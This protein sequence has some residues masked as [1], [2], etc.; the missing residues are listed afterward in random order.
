V[1]LEEEGIEGGDVFDECGPAAGESGGFDEVNNDVGGEEDGVVE[2][3][4]Y[5]D[6]DVAHLAVAVE[7]CGGGISVLDS[8][9]HALD[10]FEVVLG[11]LAGVV[12]VG[13]CHGGMIRD[14]GRGWNS[15]R[16]T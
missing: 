9:D 6:E 15:R 2:G 4:S 14:E 3:V 16:G 12:W 13:S 5:A 1:A 11:S 8:L 10:D 7:G